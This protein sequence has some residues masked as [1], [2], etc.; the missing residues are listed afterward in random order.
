MKR[1]SCSVNGRC[2]RRGNPGC[3]LP[4]CAT[5]C[6]LLLLHCPSLPSIR[7][8]KMFKI[9]RANR[10][11]KSP[12]TNEGPSGLGQGATNQGSR[13]PRVDSGRTGRTICGPGLG[14]FP[15]REL[16]RVAIGCKQN[17]A[18]VSLRRQQRLPSAAAAFFENFLCKRPGKIA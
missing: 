12:E 14:Q 18:F 13:E 7:G 2:H 15:E 5:S 17:D 4:D 8:E 10:P 11:G 6:L 1:A 9:P 16:T 3:S